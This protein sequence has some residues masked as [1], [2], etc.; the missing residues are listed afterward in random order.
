MRT[1]ALAVLLGALAPIQ[2]DAARLLEQLRSDNIE[3]RAAAAKKLRQIGKPAVEELKRAAQDPDLEFSGLAKSILEQI[4]ADTNPLLHPDAESMKATAPARFKVR[5]ATSK[6]EFAVMVTRDWAPR[7][8]DRFY[9]LV[10]S[11][12]YD[13]CRFFRVISGF[14]AQFG[15]HGDPDVSAVWKPAK[16]DDDPP[17]EKNTRGRITFATAG[18]NTRT[19]QLFINFADNSRLDAMGFTP[20]GEVVAG[21]DVVDKINAEYGEG[22]PRGKGPAQ[23]RIQSE[24]NNFLK[25]EFPRLDFIKTA[26]IAEW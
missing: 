25:D 6:G 20:F 3:Q 2:D 12:F 26:K 23:A 7:G 15:I 19:T 9:N 4:E 21:M 16:F 18:P 24:G 1:L 14:M 13:D 17:K 10:K 11:G 5:F 22:S 8:A